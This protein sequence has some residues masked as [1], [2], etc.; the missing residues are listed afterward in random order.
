MLERIKYNKFIYFWLLPFSVGI[1]LSA[2]Y[3]ITHN[4]IVKSN[5]G[6]D[7]LVSELEE[8]D[9]S[10]FFGF[11]GA[12]PAIFLRLASPMAPTFLIA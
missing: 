11:L 2:G 9:F 3:I 4:V 8:F 6:K 1:C 10:S 7:I 5:K 12:S